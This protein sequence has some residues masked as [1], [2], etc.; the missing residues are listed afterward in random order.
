MNRGRR[1]QLVHIGLV[2]LMFIWIYPFIWIATA[3]FKSQREMLL[4]GL[5]VIP[6]HATLG[7]FS[8]AWSVADFGTYTVNTV[9][10]AVGVVAVV[11]V[12]SATAG[13]ALGRGAMP[14]KRVVLALLIITMFVPHGYTIIPVFKLVNALGLNNSLAG[15]VLATAAPAHVVPILLFMGYFAGMPQELEDAAR[16]DG[17]GYVRTFVQVMLP[18]AKPI[19]GTVALFNFVAAWNAFFIPLVFT[20]GQPSQRTLGVGM[21][22]FFGQYTTDWTGLA[23]AACISLLPIIV[24][25]LFLQRTFVEGMAGAIKI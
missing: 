12:I 10:Y 24:V 15:A 14:G 4:G 18:L 9:I 1:L 25:F 2:P 13:Y 6:K 11:L 16:I 20:L 8:R 17:A 5:S 7:N 21:F 3:A 19:I 22:A 23:A